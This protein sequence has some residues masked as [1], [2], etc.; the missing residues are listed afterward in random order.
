MAR[1]L[2]CCFLN[3]DGNFCCEHWCGSYALRYLTSHASTARMFNA[4]HSQDRSG[5]VTTIGPNCAYWAHSIFPSEWELWSSLG[6]PSVLLSIRSA[7]SSEPQQP[8]PES[9]GTLA[10]TWSWLSP[11]RERNTPGLLAQTGGQQRRQRELDWN[12][13]I[14]LLKKRLKWLTSG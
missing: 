10:G 8:P 3:K 13:R 1:D 14:Q 5:V 2:I 6:E 4:V 12:S 11:P 7:G 9:T